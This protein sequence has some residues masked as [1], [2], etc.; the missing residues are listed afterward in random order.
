MPLPDLVQLQLLVPGFV[1]TFFRVAGLMLFA[2][3][4]GSTRV[5][6]RIKMMVALVMSMAM[7][8]GGAVDPTRAVVQDDMMYMAVAIAGEMLMGVAMGMIVSL[9]FIAA[10]WAGEMIGQQV[11]FNVGQAFDPQFGGG[12]NVVGDAYFMF[13]M[14]IFLLIGGHRVLV[15]GVFDSLRAVPPGAL[16]FHN[17]MLEP[18]LHFM[19]TTT[20]LALR[21]A[22][23]I[24]VT[25]LIVD[26]A[27]GCLSK[28]MPQF[29]IM[30]TG[31]SLRAIIGMGLLS[32]G[33][34]VVASV[35]EAAL[36]ESLLSLPVFWMMP[37]S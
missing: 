36:G 32:L 5:S 27:M 18:V 14:V 1:L 13:T 33:T 29:N 23:P 24:F 31:M 26:V 12:G 7:L 34:L 21:L 16:V 15:D 37:S 10:Q 9:V 6:R 17:E 30:T 19:T 20:T 3:M 22:A 11:G 8:R 2:P 4:F 28:T 35:I 25:M